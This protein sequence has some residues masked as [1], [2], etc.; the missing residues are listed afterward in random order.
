MISGRNLLRL[1]IVGMLVLPSSCISLL[2]V[3]LYRAS[4]TEYRARHGRAIDEWLQRATDQDVTVRNEAIAVLAETLG[5]I[6]D[7]GPMNCAGPDPSIWIAR[8]KRDRFL[9]DVR[10]RVAEITEV[11]ARAVE[12]KSA[13]CRDTAIRGLATV[14]IWSGADAF[15]P[16]LPT[17]IKAARDENAEIR[18]TAT[19]CIIWNFEFGFR[20]SD[21]YKG[22][23]VEDLVPIL[24]DPS[25]SEWTLS[26][27]VTILGFIGP[28]AA[29][30]LPRLEQIVVDA[31]K[32]SRNIN[33][34]Q[35]ARWAIKRIRGD[36]D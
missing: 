4:Q 14:A 6:Q 19:E 23:P 8:R 10:P 3:G 16:I 28:E 24:T 29:I 36:A 30:A 18:R 1:I 17:L 27:G 13:S 31:D 12:D 33:L 9:A 15:R 22:L 32:S 7:K 11:L 34:R 5:S 20:G 2:A 26:W 25:L 21:E 35:S